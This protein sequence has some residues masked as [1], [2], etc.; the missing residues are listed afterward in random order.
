M[1]VKRVV[2]H[3]AELSE[4]LIKLAE[5][6]GGREAAVTNPSRAAVGLRFAN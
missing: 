6:S 4:E 5:I 2:K 1:V 3:I